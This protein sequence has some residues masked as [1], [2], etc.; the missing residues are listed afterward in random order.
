M[1]TMA[2][3]VGEHVLPA[4]SGQL[5]VMLESKHITFCTI[6]QSCFLLWVRLAAPPVIDLAQPC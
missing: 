4:R 6:S 5:D 2:E 3:Q 1:Q